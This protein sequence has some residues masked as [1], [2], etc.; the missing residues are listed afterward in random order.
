MTVPNLRT[1]SCAAVWSPKKFLAASPSAGEEIRRAGRQRLCLPPLSSPTGISAMSAVSRALKKANNAF[2]TLL[3]ENTGR[4]SKGGGGGER[5]RWRLA[6]PRVICCCNMMMKTIIFI[7]LVGSND[8]LADEISEGAHSSLFETKRK[9]C[10]CPNNSPKRNYFSYIT[11]RGQSLT[12]RTMEPKNLG[13]FSL[14][15]QKRSKWFWTVRT[16]HFLFKEIKTVCIPVPFR[17]IRVS[18]PGIFSLYLR[19]ELI[20]ESRN[21][22]ERTHTFLWRVRNAYFSM[23]TDES[24]D[25]GWIRWSQLDHSWMKWSQPNQLSVCLAAEDTLIGFASDAFW[26][27]VV[28]C[29]RTTEVALTAEQS[30]FLSL[31]CLSN[32]CS[33]IA[34]RVLYAAQRR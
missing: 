8:C 26:S 13:H 4:R 2:N 24:G 14:S 3:G 7:L 20:K 32:I 6:K 11:E 16:I 34:I 19:T 12:V 27:Q 5:Y 18:L 29:H 15:S 28:R 23:I 21:L 22:R 10:F 31:T 33:W 9:S 17:W 30:G 1:F 25:R